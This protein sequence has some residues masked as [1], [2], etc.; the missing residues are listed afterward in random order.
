M[1]DEKKE[2]I[3]TTEI[4]VNLKKDDLNASQHKTDRT[5]KINYVCVCFYAF[6][7]GT[8][9]LCPLSRLKKFK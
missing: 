6:L 8:W 5:R 2:I 4:S 9:K 3:E 7:T 1:T